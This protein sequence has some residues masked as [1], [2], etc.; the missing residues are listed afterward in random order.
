[1]E[2]DVKT[3]TFSL[4]MECHADVKCLMNY[5]LYPFDTQTCK[6][7]LKSSTKNMTYQVIATLCQVPT[8]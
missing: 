4:E 1:M 2:Y 6:F 8:K 3:G 5:E 7:A